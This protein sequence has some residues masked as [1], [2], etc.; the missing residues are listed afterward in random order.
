MRKLFFIILFFASQN[1][2]AQTAVE[3]SNEFKITGKVKA[4]KTISLSDLHK[5]KTV[6][7]SHSY[8][9]PQPF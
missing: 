1:I 2:Y 3:T 5:Y 7:L 9:R 4:E 8:L 6:E